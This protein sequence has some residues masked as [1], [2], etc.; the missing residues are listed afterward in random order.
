MYRKIA[1]L[2]IILFNQLN[3]FGTTDVVL[4]NQNVW[5]YVSNNIKSPY[6]PIHLH[7]KIVKKYF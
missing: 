7:I 4:R 5:R 1:L 2:E 3:E 6:N